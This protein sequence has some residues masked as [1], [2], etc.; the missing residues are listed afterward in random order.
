MKDKFTNRIILFFQNCGRSIKNFFQ[1][2][3]AWILYGIQWI[4]AI[5]THNKPEKPDFSDGM[6]SPAGGDSTI[7]F[8]ANQLKKTD[9]DVTGAT[10]A[11]S[12]IHI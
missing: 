9:A 3:W 8:D 4:A 2:L 5:F 7:V 11:L 1:K 12:L 6:V 10:K